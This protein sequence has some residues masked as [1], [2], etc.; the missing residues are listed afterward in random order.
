[1]VAKPKTKDAIV[2]RNLIFGIPGDVVDH[3]NFDDWLD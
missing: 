3:K 1:M 2:N